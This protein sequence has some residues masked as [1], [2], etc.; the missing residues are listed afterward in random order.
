MIRTTFPLKQLVSP[1]RRTTGTNFPRS[2]RH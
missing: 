2:T 1:L